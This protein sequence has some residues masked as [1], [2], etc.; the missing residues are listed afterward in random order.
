M[1]QASKDTLNSLHGLIA[2]TLADAIKAYKGKTDPEDL[3]GLAAIANVAKGF[4]KDNGIEALPEASKPLQNL[5]SV[6]P[7]PGHVGGE[8][9]DDEYQQQATG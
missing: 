2:E 8:G 5:A 1:S 7:F 9:E 6:L 3:K 4:L